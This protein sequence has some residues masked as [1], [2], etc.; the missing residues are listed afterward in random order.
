[1]Y[2]VVTRMENP[3]YGA[4]VTKLNHYEMSM[5]LWI[6][7]HRCHVAYSSHQKDKQCKDKYSCGV[8]EYKQ[9]IMGSNG[10]INARKYNIC[11]IEEPK[12]QLHGVE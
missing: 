12:K 11:G 9:Y 3:G 6:Y 7:L 10:I 2:Y 5:T 8:S 4:P 1:M